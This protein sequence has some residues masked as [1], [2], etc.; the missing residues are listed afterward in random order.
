MQFLKRIKIPY[1]GRPLWSVLPSSI[2]KWGGAST[3][4]WFLQTPFATPFFP[5]FWADVR[6]PF[7]HNNLSQPGKNTIK[8]VSLPIQKKMGIFLQFWNK[9]PIFA[10]GYYEHIHISVVNKGKLRSSRHNRSK[11]FKTWNWNLSHLL[12][13]WHFQARQLKLELV[14]LGK[15]AVAKHPAF[16]PF[17]QY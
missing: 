6:Y 17:R 10:A 13:A 2:L 9:M 1:E 15:Q 14:R 12:V 3:R 7:I 8:Y 16:K 11:G 5:V 4:R